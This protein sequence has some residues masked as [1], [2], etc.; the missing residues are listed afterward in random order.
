MLIVTNSLQ[1][2]Y[3][4]RT[5]SRIKAF[6][7]SSS[8]P[9]PPQFNTLVRQKRATPFQ[10]QKSLSSTSKTPQ[11]HT[12]NPSVSHPPQFHTHLGSTPPSQ[13]HTPLSS[14]REHAFNANSILRQ[15]TFRRIFLRQ[16]FL[17]LIKLRQI[18]LCLENMSF[19]IF[20]KKFVLGKFVLK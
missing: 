3:R 11:F 9:H 12:K 5:K 10:P 20:L 18:I 16:I 4:P 6:L 13:F 17:R 15:I 7:G 19:K 2:S 1:Q 8:V 14:T